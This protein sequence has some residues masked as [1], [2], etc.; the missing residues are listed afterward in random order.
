MVKQSKLLVLPTKL[1]YRLAVAFCLMSL[2]PIMAGVYIA[3]LFIKFPFTM[4]PSTLLMA[5][6][7]S[8]VSIALSFLGYTLL[9][10][11]MSPI[12]DMA[13]KAKKIA[14][15]G[16]E[17]ETAKCDEDEL[18]ELSKSLRLISKNARD[19]I[20]KVDRLS[21]KDKLTG[22]YNMAY[23]RERLHEEIRRAGL[24]RR[25]CSFMVLALDGFEVFAA[26][27]GMQTAD[28]VQM[29]VANILKGELTEVDRA[30]RVTQ[31]EFALILP[32]KNKKRAMEIAESVGQKTAGLLTTP[33]RE[34][35]LVLSA[36]ISEN[37]MDG[38]TSDELVVKAQN[39]AKL[40]RG[41]K[42]LYEAFA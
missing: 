7:V 36:G 41:N 9:R 21:L 22:L 5:S 42:R 2:L 17:F 19:L 10:Q 13:E 28:D 20:E 30:A 39:R 23:M 40:A 6:L 25:C 16:L 18:Q 31:G 1:K 26:K 3:S 34:I 37:P 4:S 15:G 27:Y 35:R 29:A 33:D 32:D 12:V 8:V 24:N 11:L 14:A 38:V